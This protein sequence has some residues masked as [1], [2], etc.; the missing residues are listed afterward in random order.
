MDDSSDIVID[1][2][3]LP[4]LKEVLGA[5]I[6]GIVLQGEASAQDLTPAQLGQPSSQQ[7]GQQPCNG[8]LSFRADG[9]SC[10]GTVS[11]PKVQT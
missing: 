4:L 10:V 7:P 6:P 1:S 9:A 8:I 2:A 5:S 11:W 3:F